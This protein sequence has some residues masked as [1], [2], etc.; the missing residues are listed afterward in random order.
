MRAVLDTNVLI[1]GLFWHGPPHALLTHV[2][3][4]TLRT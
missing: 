1:A 2:R 3:G 4:G